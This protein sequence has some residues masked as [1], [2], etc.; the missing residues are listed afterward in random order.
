LLLRIAL[1]FGIVVGQ[2][3]YVSNYDIDDN[4]IVNMLDLCIPVTHYGQTDLH[5]G[6][7]VS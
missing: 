1:H 2:T 4:N 5:N 3:S 6:R 7:M